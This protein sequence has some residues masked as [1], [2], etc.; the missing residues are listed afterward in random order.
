[1]IQTSPDQ[2]ERETLEMIQQITDNSQRVTQMKHFLREISKKTIP[3]TSEENPTP[4]VDFMA[5]HA[6][7]N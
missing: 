4:M 7:S 6:C 1:M 2:R 5:S 3:T